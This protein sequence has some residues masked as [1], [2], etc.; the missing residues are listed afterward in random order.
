M[1]V[2]DL[3]QSYEKNVLLESQASASPLEQFSRWFD[4][5]QAAKVP[6]PMP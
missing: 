3:R 2:S 1:S 5:A 6:E 4:E